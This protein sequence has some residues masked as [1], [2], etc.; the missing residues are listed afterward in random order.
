MT[1]R[2]TNIAKLDALGR[3]NEEESRLVQLYCDD[4]A[5]D[6]RYHRCKENPQLRAF[7]IPGHDKDI[8]VL[9]KAWLDTLDENLRLRDLH[10]KQLTTGYPLDSIR[11]HYLAATLALQML[12]TNA[13]G[14][15]M[16]LFLIY[17][18]IYWIC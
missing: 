13:I 10:G 9:C 3:V 15:G 4:A 7:T 8:I 17:F 12:H 14:A 1:K 2:L 6:R 11:D 18:A 5:L 16:G